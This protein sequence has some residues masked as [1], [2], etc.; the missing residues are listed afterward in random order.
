MVCEPVFLGGRPLLFACGVS[1]VG[2]ITIAII[3]AV[4]TTTITPT[5]ITIATTPPSSPKTTVLAVGGWFDPAIPSS[6][7]TPVY[8][9]FDSSLAT[10][11]PCLNNYKSSSSSSNTQCVRAQFFPPTQPALKA[12]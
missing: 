3:I 2:A 7:A 6:S 11:S 10:G 12:C 8:P 1:N 9:S 5:I 4:T